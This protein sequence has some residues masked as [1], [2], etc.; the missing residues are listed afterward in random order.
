MKTQFCS[1]LLCWIIFCEFLPAQSVCGY[2]SLDVTNPIEFLGN[3]ILYEGKEIELGEKTF[4]IDGQL[5]DEVTARYPFVF[6]SFNDLVNILMIKW[7]SCL[8]QIWMAE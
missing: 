6:N 1:F 5:S 7:I 4:F 3:K 2:R 8:G